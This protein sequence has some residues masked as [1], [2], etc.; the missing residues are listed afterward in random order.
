MAEEGFG[1]DGD[2]RQHAYAQHQ[3]MQNLETELMKYWEQQ[4][5]EAANV[6]D[7]KNHTLPLARI[8]GMGPTPGRSAAIR[9]ARTMDNR[10]SAT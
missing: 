7:I 8:T 5:E 9:S 4:K 2:E 10:R 1:H 6:Q 3:G